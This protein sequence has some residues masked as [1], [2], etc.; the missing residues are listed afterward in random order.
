MAAAGTTSAPRS[1][2]TAM[3]KAG[4]APP[5][6]DLMTAVRTTERTDTEMTS[7]AVPAELAAAFH[8]VRRLGVAFSGGVDSSV[9]LALAARVL[10]R[11][12]GGRRARGL[13][14]P[15]RRGAGGGPRGGPAIGARSSRSRPGRATGRP[16]GPTGRTAATT[17]R[18]SCSAGSTTSCRRRRAWTRSRTAENADDAARTDRPGARAATEHGCRRPLA[19]AGLTKADVRRSG[20]S[21]GC[22]ARTSRR[23]PAWPPGSRTSRR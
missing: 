11:E 17:A 20:P 2:A 1:P 4:P 13:P 5:R 3:W 19:D 12:P 7:S 21:S 22:R 18:T 23:R 6:E 16:T 14:Q 8:G 15:R 9:L 10:G